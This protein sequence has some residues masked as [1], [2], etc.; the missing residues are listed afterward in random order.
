MASM[1]KPDERAVMTYVSSYYHAFSSSQ[2]VIYFKILFYNNSQIE[3]RFPFYLFIV[4]ESSLYMDIEQKTV[5]CRY[6]MVGCI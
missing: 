4:R 2:Q 6:C 3:E 1:E 5:L